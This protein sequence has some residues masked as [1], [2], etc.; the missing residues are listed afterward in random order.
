VKRPDSATSTHCSTSMQ[1]KEAPLHG[2]RL[3]TAIYFMCFFAILCMAWWALAAPLRPIPETKDGDSVT[4]LAPVER[5]ASGDKPSKS[6]QDFNLEAFRIPVWVAP[7]TPPLPPPPAPP[8]AKEPAPPALKWQLLAITNAGLGSP[9]PRAVIYDAESDSVLELA[10]GQVHLGREVER[11]EH[12]VIT[13][14]LGK[15]SYTL[16]LERPTTGSGPGGEK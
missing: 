11:I 3:H 16:S 8:P 7:P 6:D 12:G 4:T 2:A 10:P 5:G 9:S 15:H 1:P 13:I 14:K